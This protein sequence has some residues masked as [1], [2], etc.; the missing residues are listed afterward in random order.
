MGQQQRMLWI[1]HAGFDAE[2]EDL[3]AVAATFRDRGAQLCQALF[4][5]GVHDRREGRLNDI[6]ELDGEPEAVHA[7]VGDFIEVIVRVVIHRVHQLVFELGFALDGAEET[8]GD[9]IA[10]ERC[11]LGHARL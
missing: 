3:D 5:T 7:V 8:A 11:A 10:N 6:L 2:E 9:A 1:H 4:A